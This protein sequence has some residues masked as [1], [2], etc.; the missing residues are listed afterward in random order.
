MAEALYLVTRTG[1]TK[2]L[3]NGV[4]AVLINS[5][6][7]GT[8]ADIIAEAVIGLNRAYPKDAE[9]SDPFPD[10]YFDTVQSPADLT[11]GPVPDDRDVIIFAD[12][13]VLTSEA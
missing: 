13:Q 11:S 2:R 12:N 4:R 10:G 8:N 5:D 7:A 6:D 3:I 1:N 9:G